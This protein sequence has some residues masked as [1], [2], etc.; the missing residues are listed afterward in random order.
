MSKMNEFVAF[1]AL[2][3]LLKANNKE[4]LLGETYERCERQ[5]KFDNIE[6]KNEV[7]ELYDLFSLEELNREIANIVRPVDI[8]AEVEIIYQTIEGLHAACPNHT[9]DWYFTGNYPTPGGIKVVNKAFINYYKKV[10][11]RAYF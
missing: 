5:L 2:V 4:Y 8:S 3:N 9:G 7:Q 1:R 10:D 6:P 11:E